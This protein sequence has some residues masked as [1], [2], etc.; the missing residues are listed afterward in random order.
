MWYQGWKQLCTCIASTLL[1]ILSSWS[2][3]PLIYSNPNPHRLNHNIHSFSHSSFIHSINIFHI[4]H[5]ASSWSSLPK[6]HPILFLLML[7]QW[8]GSYIFDCGTGGGCTQQLWCSHIPDC[9][10]DPLWCQRFRKQSNC[11][12][13]SIGGWLGGA[14]PWPHAGKDGTFSQGTVPPALHFSLQGQIRLCYGQ[15]CS[16]RSQEVKWY[17]LAL[18]L[19]VFL[20][21]EQVALNSLSLQG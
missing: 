10:S 19:F 6:A 8:P 13:L 15:K 17:I 16:F 14:N 4:E 12:R 5:S 7:L 1:V 2:L 3:L 20:T 9:V 18:S 21:W 11:R